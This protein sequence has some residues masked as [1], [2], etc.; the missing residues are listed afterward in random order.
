MPRKRKRQSAA[1]SVAGRLRELLEEASISQ[2]ELARRAGVS[3][4]VVSRLL[5]EGNADMTLGIA[6]RLCWAMGH[7]P[8]ALA[9]AVFAEWQAQ[10]GV[11]QW[12][13]QELDRRRLQQK[14]EALR[15]RIA[16]YRE[17]LPDGPEIAVQL[18]RR[19]GEGMIRHWEEQAEDLEARLR[20]LG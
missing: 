9:G 6:C 13:H 20:K 15:S 17:H 1:V 19:W 3:P 12:Q 18:T 10:P 16:D 14:L 11:V 2:G 5:A 4:Q 8:E 7:G